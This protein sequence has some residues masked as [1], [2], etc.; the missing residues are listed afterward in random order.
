MQPGTI[1]I[2]RLKKYSGQIIVASWPFEPQNFSQCHRKIIPPEVRQCNLRKNLGSE[3]DGY[4]HLSTV[5]ATY[6]R[7]FG[8]N[9]EHKVCQRPART[10]IFGQMNFDFDH[11]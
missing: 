6:W 11:S 1:T 10:G 8:V 4:G 2:A 7:A 9:S 5:N 3:R